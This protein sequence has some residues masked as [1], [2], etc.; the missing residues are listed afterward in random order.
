LQ[1]FEV[2]DDF[3]RNQAQQLSRTK[4]EKDAEIAK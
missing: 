1:F 2:F 3:K 4:L